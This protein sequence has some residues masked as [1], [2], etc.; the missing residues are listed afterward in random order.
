MNDLL[1]LADMTMRF[2]RTN[3]AKHLRL[4]EFSTLPQALKMVAHA[5]LSNDMNTTSAHA[6]YSFFSD[7]SC[8]SVGD[9]GPPRW[10]MSEPFATKEDR[11]GH[12]QSISFSCYA[13]T[14]SYLSQPLETG[15]RTL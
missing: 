8:T 5:N 1:R 14:T 15:R 9:A 13:R 6:Q 11:E 10:A 7:N 2:T 4:V 12:K 3:L